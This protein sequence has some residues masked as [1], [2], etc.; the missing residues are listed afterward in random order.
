MARR[1]DNKKGFLVIELSRLEAAVL[2]FGLN[3]KGDCICMSCN[4]IIDEPIY[5]IAVL[6]DTMCK[7]CYN[8]FIE[9]ATY[10]KEDSKIEKRNYD[11]YISMIRNYN[12]YKNENI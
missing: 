7:D 5:Y 3:D 9:N 4:N 11:Y 1:V 10:Y 6:N 2:G 8:D 12:Y